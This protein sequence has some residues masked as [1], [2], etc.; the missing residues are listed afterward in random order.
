[1]TSFADN[2]SGYAASDE[3]EYIAESFASF[4]KGENVIDPVMERIFKGLKR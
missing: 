1:M 3:S 2:V 4:I